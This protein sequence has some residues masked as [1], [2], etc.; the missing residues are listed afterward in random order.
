ML[1]EIVPTALAKANTSIIDKFLWAKIRWGYCPDTVVPTTVQRG[2]TG[3]VALL[4]EPAAS[5]IG[6]RMGVPNEH[7]CTKHG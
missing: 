4:V 5:A 1:F 3:V 2:I 6:E 7:Q